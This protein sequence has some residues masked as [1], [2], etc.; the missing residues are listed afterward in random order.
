MTLRMHIAVL[1]L[2]FGVTVPAVSAE[3]PGPNS[4][5][6]SPVVLASQR[7]GLRPVPPAESPTKP[8]RPGELDCGNCHVGK[9]QGVLQMYL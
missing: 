6:L 5:V 8:H 1:G 7:P 2:L 3:D 4:S 9:H